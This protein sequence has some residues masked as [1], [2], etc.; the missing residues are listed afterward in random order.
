MSFQFFPLDTFTHDTFNSDE[1]L[2]ITETLVSNSS[3]DLDINSNTEIICTSER[4]VKRKETIR[5]SEQVTLSD[6]FPT[7]W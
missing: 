7:D 4:K 2:E 3:F 5:K 1:L 6:D